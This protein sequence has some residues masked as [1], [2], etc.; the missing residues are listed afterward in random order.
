M[1]CWLV[2]VRVLAVS[3]VVVRMFLVS[4][5]RVGI[6]VVVNVLIVLVVMPAIHVNVNRILLPAYCEYKIAHS[7]LGGR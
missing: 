6:A 5:V 4:S 7:G 1:G 3:V 2:A